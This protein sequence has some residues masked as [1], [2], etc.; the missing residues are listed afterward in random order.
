MLTP[1][2]K[3]SGTQKAVIRRKYRAIQAFIKKEKRS[4]IYNLISHLKELGKKPA[5]KTQNQLKMGNNKD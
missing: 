2:P 4:Q 1:Q 5:N 3:N